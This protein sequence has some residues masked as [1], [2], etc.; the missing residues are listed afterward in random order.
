MSESKKRQRKRKSEEDPTDARDEE[1]SEQDAEHGSDDTTVARFDLD[2]HEEAEDS[3]QDVDAEDEFHARIADDPTAI[4]LEL[5]RRML[6]ESNADS[7]GTEEVPAFNDDSTT[8]LGVNVEDEAGT[9]LRGTAE[10]DDDENTEIDADSADESLG[11]D[12]SPS[13]DDTTLIANDHS[14]SQVQT[15]IAKTIQRPGADTGLL[16]FA[17]TE[18]LLGG[19]KGILKGRFVLEEHIGSG[20]MGTV[21]KAR[22]LRKVEARDRNPYLAVK[23]L[24]DDFKKH[25]DAFIALQREAAKSQTLSHPNI[26]RIYDF[27]K[28]GDTPFMTME[29]LEGAEL[30]DLL[31]EATDGLQRDQAWKILRGISAGL[32]RA[33]E[34]NI[35]HSDFKPGNVF[36]SQDN[37]AKILDF[38]IARAV[39]HTAGD[40]E[41]DAEDGAT[42]HGDR[43]LFDPGTL[44]ALTPAYASLEMLNGAEPDPRDD[45]YGLALV[46]YLMF[47][48]KHPYD[49]KPADE[50]R[51]DGMKPKR[52][53]GLTGRQWR[54]IERGLQ[55]ERGQRIESVEEF[56]QLL[57]EKARWALRPAIAVVAVVAMLGVV[58]ASMML[59]GAAQGNRDAIAQQ[60]V[61]DAQLADI[62]AMLQQDLLDERWEDQL[63]IEIQQ[64][65][66]MLPSGDRRSD[67]L[68]ANVLGRYLDQV[69]TLRDDFDAARSA[70]ERA[71]RYT[72]GG[73]YFADGEMIVA[74]ALK[75]RIAALFASA[76]FTSEWDQRLALELTR[77]R[78]YLRDGGWV[79]EADKQALELYRVRA[80]RAIND[81]ELEAAA[82]IIQAGRPYA[83]GSSF[84]EQSAALTAALEAQRS[85]AEQERLREQEQRL[86]MERRSQELAAQRRAV[87]REQEFQRALVPLNEELRCGNGFSIR[88]VAAFVGELRTD[89]PERFSGAERKVV[90]DIA[91]CIGELMAIDGEKARS[92]KRT[93][94]QIFPG[95]QALVTIRFDPCSARYLV[96]SGASGSRGSYCEDVLSTGGVGPRLV[97]VPE[98]GEIE[99][100]AI[101]KYEVSAA[102]IAVF[103]RSAGTCVA[104]K[105]GDGRLPATLVAIDIARAYVQWLSEQSGH[106]YRLPTVAEWRYAAAG[107]GSDPD[108]NRNC[109]LNALGIHKGDSLQNVRNGQGN[110][111]G[112]VNHLGNVQEWALE[113]SVVMAVG[114]AHVD[115]MGDCT[116]E[117]ARAHSG[118]AD[119]ITGFRVFRE[120]R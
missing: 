62:D 47:T 24:N 54:A 6:E 65:R 39:H 35:T 101:G 63:F 68:N 107:E 117:L 20:G 103:C 55:F 44:G 10:V 45:I 119:P 80:T 110:D 91:A 26:V 74:D 69:K 28:D 77:A 84:A 41:G 108:P 60:A 73:E 56:S 97:V 94:L 64:I 48:G 105:S 102:D 71:R 92:V 114:G 90:S 113:G 46:A 70:V 88:R 37:V 14:R 9:E 15:E 7:G 82:R 36:V 120:L 43:T 25:P 67:E 58:A 19:G 5:R 27:D 49:R 100:F 34:A 87:E 96:G 8:L 83:D 66:S 38:G 93:A 53:R 98:N 99:S 86:A 116:F 59:E 32:Q 17:E 112:L 78:E 18:H 12:A 33:H 89:Y 109:T 11:T 23:V 81:G 104:P 118:D 115:A 57:F 95:S 2:A 13:D 42:S 72:V 111:W 4:N 85:R 40:A 30:A 79:R 16:G 76:A 31:R 50:A 61:L 51:E 75:E 52:I 106:D 3:R 22:D 21:Y 1:S 29:M